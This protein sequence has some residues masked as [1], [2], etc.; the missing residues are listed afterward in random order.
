MSPVSA[1]DDGVSVP[2][3]PLGRSLMRSRNWS[4]RSKI[5]AMV[6]VPLIALLALW[7]F[8]TTATAGPAIDLL[9]ARD[10]VHRLGDPGL[11]LIAQLQRERH[12]SAIYLS[13]RKSPLTDLT[14]QR[15]ATD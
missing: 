5:I 11:Q 14:A 1:R 8:A 3:E 6:A 15:A 13:A 10:A 7:I 9:N 4:I 12:F 2:A